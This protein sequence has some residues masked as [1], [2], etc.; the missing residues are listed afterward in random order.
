MP[1]LR[2]EVRRGVVLV[3]PNFHRRPGLQQK[4]PTPNNSIAHGAR[5]RYPR[6]QMGV[7]KRHR[8]REMSVQRGTTRSEKRKA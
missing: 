1:V 6:R 5:E 8:R 3:V 7:K 4:L 2:G